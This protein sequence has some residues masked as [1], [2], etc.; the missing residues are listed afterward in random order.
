MSADSREPCDAF[1]DIGPFRFECVGHT[2]GPRARQGK[3]MH[4]SGGPEEVGDVIVTFW[5]SDRRL[6]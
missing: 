6:P 1:I 4:V 5:T 3:I 2:G